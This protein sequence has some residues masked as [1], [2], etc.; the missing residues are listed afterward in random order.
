MTVVM[1]KPENEVLGMDCSRDVVLR[2]KSVAIRQHIR[3]DSAV[4]FHFILNP[5]L[6]WLSGW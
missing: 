4:S 1:H 5:W 2:A 6:L 3:S